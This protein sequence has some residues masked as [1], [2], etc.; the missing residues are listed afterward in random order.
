MEHGDYVGEAD[1]RGFARGGLGQIGNVVDEWSRLQQVRL[2]YELGH[3]GSAIFVIALEII[4]VEQCQ[5]LAV[6][7]EDFEDADIGLVDRNV[8]RFLK[9]NSYRLRA[10]EQDA[11][12]RT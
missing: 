11:V 7:V 9:G 6:G 1:Q 12:L 2:A 8:V 5:V 4:A 10:G 3:P